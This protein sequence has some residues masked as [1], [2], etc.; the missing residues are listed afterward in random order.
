MCPS[1]FSS[2]FAGF[3]SYWEFEAFEA[4]LQ[5]KLEHQQLLPLPHTPIQQLTI[6]APEQ[7]YQCLNCGENWALSSP[8]NAWRG[9]FLPLAVARAHIRK[10]A[11]KD[12]IKRVSGAAIAIGVGAFTL[13]QLLK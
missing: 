6:M 9:Y 2:G 7:I 13:W 12:R 5:Q 3:P 4:E 11:V 8:D 1:C 10:S